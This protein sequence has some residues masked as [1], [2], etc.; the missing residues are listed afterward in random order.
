M[1]IISKILSVFVAA[2]MG[3]S[4]L[5]CPLFGQEIKPTD[6]KNLKLSFGAIADV[7]LQTTATR[8]LTLRRGMSELSRSSIDAV[9]V[10]GDMTDHGDL[11]QY[12][13]FYD[14]VRSSLRGPAFIPAIGNHDTWGTH[15]K[16][17][18]DGGAYSRQCFVNFYNAY[19]GRDIEKPYYSTEI[20][21]YK[22]ICMS[23]EAD[24]T[25]AYISNEQI[26]WLDSELFDATRENKPVFVISH[27][28]VRGTN[29]QLQVWPGN[30]EFGAQSDD[31]EAV[32]T[33]Y[34]NVFFITGHMHAPFRSDKN[35]MGAS[36]QT[37][38]GVT[39]VNLPCYMYFNA[40]GALTPTGCG[41]IFEVYDNYVLLRARNIVMKHWMPA[42]DVTVLLDKVVKK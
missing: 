5:V 31:V 27:W 4:S 38:G 23:T 18:D 35:P 26:E 24:H 19:S 34:K 9:L 42:Y 30:G 33:K 28:L 20:N 40:Y 36:V 29:G 21:G 41:Y 7:H 17:V 12:A 15:E 13:A 16:G 10:A 3:A 32:L 14:C 8:E 11:D 22:F 2:V 1:Q 6:A 37:V 39:Y 25:D